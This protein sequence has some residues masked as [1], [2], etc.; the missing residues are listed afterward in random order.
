MIA[1]ASAQTDRAPDL[2][3][4]ALAVLAQEIDTLLARPDSTRAAPRPDATALPSSFSGSS[5]PS[6][7]CFNP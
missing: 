3:V 1:T 5:L 4:I 7:S 6:S 2:Q